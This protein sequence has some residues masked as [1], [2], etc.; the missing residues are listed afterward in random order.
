MQDRVVAAYE[1]QDAVRSAYL[2]RCCR[3]DFDRDRK[4]VTA[5]GIA[6]ALATKARNAE[7]RAER[8]AALRKARGL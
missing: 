6:K 2:D 4:Y 1:F 3:Q 7:I 5:Q 8:D